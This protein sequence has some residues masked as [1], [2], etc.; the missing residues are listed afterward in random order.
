MLW[1]EKSSKSVILLLPT[2]EVIY[3]RPME[4]PSVWVRVSCSSTDVEGLFIL[5]DPVVIAPKFPIFSGS[6]PYPNLQNGVG[7]TVE[8]FEAPINSCPIAP[9]ELISVT[10]ESMFTIEPEENLSP[11]EP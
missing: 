2:E 9:E 5:R 11:K 8:L 3:C 1:I 10:S 7:V 6:A 4:L